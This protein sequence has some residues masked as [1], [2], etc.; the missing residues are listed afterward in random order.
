MKAKIIY[1][2]M[3]NYE[4]RAARVAEELMNNFD[5][6]D[7]EFVINSGGVFIIEIDGEVVYSKKDLIGC[8]SQRFPHEGEI[9]SLIKSKQE[10]QNKIWA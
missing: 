4:P 3:W 2:N 5:G 8:D 1:C 10:K 6:V 7:V 9:S